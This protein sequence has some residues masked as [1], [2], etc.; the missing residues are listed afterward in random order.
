[1]CQNENQFEIY[2]VILGL[3]SSVYTYT[4]IYMTIIHTSSQFV[5]NPYIAARKML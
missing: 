1:M 5:T 2:T 4:H 3:L